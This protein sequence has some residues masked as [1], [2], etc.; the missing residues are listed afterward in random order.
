MEH[1]GYFT[2]IRISTFDEIGYTLNLEERSLKQC[3]KDF[4]KSIPM[5]NLQPV[6][7]IP[8][9]VASGK[10]E[11]RLA[12][13]HRGVDYLLIVGIPSQLS[14]RLVRFQIPQ[15]LL[16]AR[17]VDEQIESGRVVVPLLVGSY[18]SPQC[19]QIC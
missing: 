6:K 18:L 12:F 3:V 9:R 5:L 7:S 2:K 13:E 17:Q 19:R 10:I 4:V 8:L 11:L 14:P 15:L 16:L 1:R